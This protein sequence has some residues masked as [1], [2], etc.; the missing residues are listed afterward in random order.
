MFSCKYRVIWM[1]SNSKAVFFFFSIHSYLRNFLPWSDCESVFI[2]F[3]NIKFPFQ[4]HFLNDELL[5][6]DGVRE[7]AWP[8]Y[9][10]YFFY[11]F[12][13]P[14]LS[15]SVG[16]RNWGFLSRPRH[17]ARTAHQWLGQ[18]GRHRHSCAVGGCWGWSSVLGTSCCVSVCYCGCC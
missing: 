10:F 13:S 2:S 3:P 7:A 1:K 11:F 4:F 12:H 15:T 14:P 9:F 17:K 16:P 8:V 5:S 18:R 6:A